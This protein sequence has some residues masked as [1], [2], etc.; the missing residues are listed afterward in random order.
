MTIPVAAEPVHAAPLPVAAART[1]PSVVGP[2]VARTF[3]CELAAVPALLWRDLHRRAI[4][5][6][7]YYDPLWAVPVSQSARGHEGAQALLAWNGDRLTGLMPVRW[8]RRALSLPG[9]LL[10]GW[11]AYAP[12]TVPTLDR[13]Q[14]VHAA[15]GLLEAARRAGARALLLPA[16]ATDGAAYAAL[17]QALAERG[18]RADILRSYRRAGLDATLD[19]DAALREALGAKKLKELRRQRHRLEDDGALAFSVA[20][21]PDDVAASLEKFLALEARGWKGARGTALARDEGNAKFIRMA[22]PA[23]AAQRGFEIVSLSRNGEALAC[24]LVLRDRHT[25]YFFKIAIDERLARCSPGVQLT[26]DLTRH[27]CADPAIVFADSSTDLPH[28]MI[29]HV[30]RRRIEIADIFISLLPRDPVAAGLR[31][32][33]GARYRAIDAAKAARRIGMNLRAS[34]R[35]GSSGAASFR[36]CPP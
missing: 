11:S 27:L 15:G 8:S 7:A 30:W 4:E 1:H 14:A 9:P 33:A 6:N 25:A 32:L 22:A 18:L 23:L 20:I 26:L 29:D 31:L 19:A 17:K 13:D 28:P 12:L 5:P 10:V 24:G 35:D 34:R 36:G 2:G 21:T 3:P 16:L